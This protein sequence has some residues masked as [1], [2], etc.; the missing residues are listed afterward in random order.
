MMLS[1]WPPGSVQNYLVHTT[2]PRLQV[3]NDP[4]RRR[5]PA[6]GPPFDRKMAKSTDLAL[7]EENRRRELLELFELIE[8][9]KL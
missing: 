7:I 3:Q 5:V 2:I 1:L 4:W 9:I 8:L 6:Q